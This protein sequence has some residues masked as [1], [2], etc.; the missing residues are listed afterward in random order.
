LT[1]PPDSLRTY[2]QISISENKKTLAFTMDSGAVGVVDLATKGARRMKSQHNSVSLIKSLSMNVLLR[3]QVFK[4][5]A[6]VAF[7]PERPGE[8][9]SGGYDSTLLHFNF[10]Q[11]TIL[12]RRE[13]CKWFFVGRRVRR[14]TSFS[15]LLVAI[16]WRIAVSPLRALHLRFIHRGYCCG[17]R[18][19]L[20]MDR[21]GWR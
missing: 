1:C 4:I 11:G 18:R 17:H 12:S 16:I 19:R 14:I 9:V 13:L 20:L 10:T 3:E 7:I 5:C 2:P 15:S 21:Y 8:L 6:S